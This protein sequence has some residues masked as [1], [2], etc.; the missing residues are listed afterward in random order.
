MEIDCI[1]NLLV[2]LNHLPQ[3]IDEDPLAA[4]DGVSQ[5]AKGPDL[6]DIDSCLG[7]PGAIFR[8]ALRGK[9]DFATDG[10]FDEALPEL[11]F[12]LRRQTC[13]L[14]NGKSHSGRK[15][16][17]LRIQSNPV[18]NAFPCTGGVPLFIERNTS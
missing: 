8:E 16:T 17:P 13:K 1:L 14:F 6:I 3:L 15:S 5:L 12:G 18:G 7:E 9:A 4:N 10:I 2:T 11:L